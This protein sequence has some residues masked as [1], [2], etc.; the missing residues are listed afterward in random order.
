MQVPRCFYPQGSLFRILGSRGLVGSLLLTPWRKSRC[1]KYL[2]L[3][4]PCYRRR[5]RILAATLSSR[6]PAFSLCCLVLAGI[7]K[8]CHGSFIVL[9]VWIVGLANHWVQNSKKP[10]KLRLQL[11]ITFGLDI[12]AV[13][14]NLLARSVTFRLSSFIIGSFLQF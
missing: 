3:C 12:F 10:K 4:T 9:A 7:C 5:L 11:P 2:L 8:K 6:L 13:Q 1:C 14:L